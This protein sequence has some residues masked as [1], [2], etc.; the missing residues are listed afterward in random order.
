MFMNSDPNSIS[1]TRN[2]GKE[3]DHM[4]LVADCLESLRSPDN[5]PE[6]LSPE[7]RS[8]LE[9]YLALAEAALRRAHVET[10]VS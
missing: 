3:N 5:L 10:K 6:G 2:S 8:E 1:F 9:E 4:K 7:T